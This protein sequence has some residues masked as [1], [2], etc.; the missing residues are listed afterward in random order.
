MV[1]PKLF[2]YNSSFSVLRTN[3]KITGNLKITVDSKGSVSFN[4]FSA[5]TTLSSKNFK[6]FNVTGKNAFN[7]DVYNFF[8]Q[9]QTPIESIF[10]VAKKT[11]GETKTSTNYAGQY[12]F[13]YGSGASLFIDPNY[14]EAFSYFSPLWIK[15]ELPDFFVIFKVPGPLNYSYT[16]NVTTINSKTFY[17]VISDYNSTYINPSTNLPDYKIKYG[18]DLLGND[19]YYSGGS[20]FEGSLSYNSYSSVEGNYI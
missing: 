10:E 5:N 19:V 11:N 6:K 14:P 13:F 4:S 9:G 18:L 16:E 1:E 2:D 20:I 12:D 3:P 7:V 15:D 8:Q 17:K